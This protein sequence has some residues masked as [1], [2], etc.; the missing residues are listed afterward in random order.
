MTIAA[1]VAVMLHCHNLQGVKKGD[2]Q[3]MLSIT[4]HQTIR[5]NYD[6]LGE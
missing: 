6:P 3:F 2:Y 5:D 1:S 4:D